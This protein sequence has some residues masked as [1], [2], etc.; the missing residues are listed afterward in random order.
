MNPQL[1]QTEETWGR[2][3]R[4]EA[5]PIPQFFTRPRLTVA[6]V[7]E[8]VRRTQHL[9][10]HTLPQ[11]APVVQ[12]APLETVP[13]IV[14]APNAHEHVH[15][16]EHHDGHDCSAHGPGHVHD[17]SALATSASNRAM[18]KVALVVQIVLLCAEVFGGIAFNSLALL[19]DAAH[20]LADVG[21]MVLA[22]WAASIAHRHV[23]GTSGHTRP[24]LLAATINASTLLLASVWIVY[25]AFH[26]ITS[27]DLIAAGPAAAIAVLG[28]GANLVTVWVLRRA[29]QG[30][31]NIKAAVAH[32]ATDAMSSV[33][34]IVAMLVVGATGIVIIDPLLSVVL[35]VIIVRMA[36]PLFRNSLAHLRAHTPVLA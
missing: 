11:A 35:A 6:P 25:E 27:P 10:Q 1:R 9:P 16:H 8:P 7:A 34:V 15:A 21:A 3:P 32:A 24:E 17:Y 28:L 33:G 5:P 22:L 29:D 2:F 12:V 13:P 26:R 19:S 14:S 36:L 23:A 31:L 20:M 30:N 4:Y 18:L